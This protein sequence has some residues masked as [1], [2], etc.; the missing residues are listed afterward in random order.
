MS[1]LYNVYIIY[2]EADMKG[3]NKV[4]I[5]IF[6]FS[7]LFLVACSE[8]IPPGEDVPPDEGGGQYSEYSQI[9]QNV[10]N[11]SN[12]NTLISNAE[13][14]S[15]YYESA[16]FDPHPYAFLEDNGHD[17]VAIKVG[18]LDCYTCSYILDD[19]PNNLYINTRVENPGEYYTNYLLTY[20]L[21]DK[22]IS[23]YKL[24]HNKPTSSVEFYVQ[25]VFM[26]DE[27]SKQKT[28]IKIEK[29]N[30]TVDAFDKIKQEMC[31]LELTSTYGAD[32]I[33]TNWVNDKNDVEHFKNFDLRILPS[34]LSESEVLHRDVVIYAP[35]GSTEWP[36]TINN[37]YHRP[38]DHPHGIR[39]LSRTDYEITL[40]T[41][42]DTNLRHVYCKDLRYDG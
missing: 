34:Y 19:E 1:A 22:E 7:L 24:T 41:T 39:A 15:H 29:A 16:V 42:Q 37:A 11:S 9:L 4:I 18:T 17:V 8:P 5:I 26:N 35:F 12:Y 33:F 10:L 21:T 32:I 27:I 6:A 13:A 28:P 2:T 14:S 25:A 40:F 30:I 20:T 36:S 23:D 3:I 38:T 31:D